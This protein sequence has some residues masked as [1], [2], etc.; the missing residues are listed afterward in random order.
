MYPYKRFVVFEKGTFNS[1]KKCVEFEKCIVFNFTQWRNM[2][3]LKR[4]SEKKYY[5]S[6]K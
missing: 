6:L 1:R 2:S 4:V 3:F 5:T